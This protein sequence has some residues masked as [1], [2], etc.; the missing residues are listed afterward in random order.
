MS[1]Y[2]KY[3]AEREGFRIVEDEFGF[4]TFIFTVNGCY[5]R[6][7]Y[8]IP[9]FRNGKIASQYADKVAAIARANGYKS[10]IGTVCPAAK[11]STDSLRVLLAYGFT[12]THVDGPLIYFAKEI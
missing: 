9:E 8:V 12:L 11:G 7:I 1:L 5:I 3:I 6:D 2:A 10:L 4:A